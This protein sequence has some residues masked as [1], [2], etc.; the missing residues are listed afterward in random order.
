MPRLGGLWLFCR[1]VKPDGVCAMADES[2][3]AAGGRAMPYNLE[4]EQGVIGGLL[5][6]PERFDSIEGRLEADDF[7]NKGYG[8]IFAAIYA[9][10]MA[11]KPLDILILRDELEKRGELEL[12]GGAAALAALTDSVPTGANVEYYAAIVRERSVQRKLIEAA[13][14]IVEAAT[15]N[16]AVSSSELLDEAERAIFQIAE[17]GSTGEP[18]TMSSIIKEAWARI[19]AYAN[20]RGAVHGVMTN[21]FE[22]DQMLT[23][24]HGGEMLIVAG[25][26][27]MGKSTFALNIARRV[28]VDNNQG[29]AIFS[30]EMTAVNMATN[31]LCAHARIDAQKMRKGE[32]NHEEF[33]HL[34]RSISSLAHSPIFIDD[35][36]V[37]TISELRGKARRLKKKHDIQLVVI[38]YLQL[39]TGSAK[40]Q[41]RSREQEVSEISRGIKALAKELDIP[42]IAL[43]QLS[44]KPEGRADPRPIMSDLRESGAIEQDADVVMLLH[45]P[46]YYNQEDAPGQA[47]VIVA[48]QRN[49]PT[50]TANLAFIKNQLRFEPL[51]LR[52]EDGLAA[53]DL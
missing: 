52:P 34:G 12:V 35:S 25:R 7:Y 11:G 2:E 29:V 44:R 18:A 37:L 28:A 46:D 6:S 16:A 48:K 43:S 13:T 51:S 31:I 50:G 27:S 21:Y 3:L 47:E 45:R 5:L 39:M 1:L 15:A 10:N 32:M 41:N 30:L 19:E 14:G 20:N 22:L 4:A 24:L 17:H 53:D 42:I 36:S 38:D 40:S 49:G 9:L 23:G 8:R 33:A 26:P